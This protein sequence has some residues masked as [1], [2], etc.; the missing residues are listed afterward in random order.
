MKIGVLTTSFPRREGDLAGSFVLG[1]ARALAK[2]GH[3]IEVLCPSH[4]QGTAPT[5]AQLEVSWVRYLPRQLEHTFYGA[6]VIDNLRR[7]PWTA[8]GLAPFSL[9]LAREAHA[10]TWDAVVSHWALPCA[11]VAP[12]SIPHL[13]V[14]HSADVFALEHLPRVLAMQ[15][16]RAADAMVFSSR[17]LRKRFLNRLSAMQSAEAAQRAHVCPMGIDPAPKLKREA[18]RR[19]LELRGPTALT[20]SRLVPIKGLEYAIEAVRNSNWQLMIAGEGPERARL[21]RLA[22]G[23]RVRF[24]GHV[25]GA[26]KSRWLSAADAFVLPSIPLAS[27]RT[28]GMPTGVLEAM[29]HGLPVVASDTGGLR[30]VVHHGEDGLLVAPRDS[31]AIA[32]ALSQLHPSMRNFARE[33]AAQYHWDVLAPRFEELLAR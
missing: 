15:V 3:T 26:A 13:A 6:G 28:E 16:A 17:D 12:R 22:R 8:I 2:L 5:F 20:M 25:T 11:L 33:T 32:L 19:E 1:F 4:A 29:E 10:R 23:A 18:C 7:A 24:L 14:C 9:A 21:E 27:G 30:D 31:A